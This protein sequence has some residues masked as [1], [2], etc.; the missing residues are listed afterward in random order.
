MEKMRSIVF[1]ILNLD[2]AIRSEALPNILHHTG[3]QDMTKP[4]E[5]KGSTAAYLMG[6]ISQVRQIDEK[7]STTD[8]ILQNGK[9]EKS[10][11]RNETTTTF[12]FSI[13]E[14]T[15]VTDFCVKIHY[16]VILSFEK[17]A[18]QLCKYEC[19][20]VAFF[21]LQGKGGFENWADMPDDLMIPYFAMVHYL[22]RQRA[23]E[24]LLAAGFRGVALPIP[25]NLKMSPAQDTELISGVPNRP[26]RAPRK[27][28]S[29]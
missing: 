3:N 13:P 23:E 24:H 20:S 28:R 11:I 19:T 26:G 12:E 8:P 6:V 4:S 14:N 17:D 9:G 10:K 29:L 21:Q 5:K 15:K 2:F 25:D 27:K 16:T 22:A 18:R 7:L 1:V